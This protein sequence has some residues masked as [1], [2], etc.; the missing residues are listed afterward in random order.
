LVKIGEREASLSRRKEP[1][2]IRE[3][4]TS[5]EIQ[6]VQNGGDEKGSDQ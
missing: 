2:E 5:G 3:K 1:K 6:V 4:V